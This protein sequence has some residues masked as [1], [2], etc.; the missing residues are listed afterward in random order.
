MRIMCATTAPLFSEYIAPQ[1]RDIVGMKIRMTIFQEEER[2]P[3]VEPSLL[4]RQGRHAEEF[5]GSGQSILD[6]DTDE[7]DAVQL[8]NHIEKGEIE[9]LEV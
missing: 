9:G 5:L 7:Q 3:A 4:L 2:S 6:F 8:M 1:Y